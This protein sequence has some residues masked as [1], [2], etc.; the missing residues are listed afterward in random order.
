MPG[1]RR[2]ARTCDGNGTGRVKLLL[3]ENLSRRIVPLIEADYPGTT[4]VALVGLERARDRE[5]WE[6][7]RAHGYVIVTQ[8]VDFNDLAALLGTPPKVVWLRLGNR[9]R[10]HIARS[11]IE[12][13]HEIE[14]ALADAAVSCVELI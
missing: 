7:A 13:R 8:D 1:I 10:Q 12:R 3:D 4:Q 14:A 9:T 5:V 6:Y 11:L 2:R